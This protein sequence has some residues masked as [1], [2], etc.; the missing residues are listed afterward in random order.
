MRL[1]AVAVAGRGLVPPHEPVFGADDEAL[2]RGRAAFETV[3]VYGGRPFRLDAHLERLGASSASL[4][5]P[6][7]RPAELEQIVALAVE[8]AGE[9]ESGLRLYWT[10]STLAAT[11]WQL[12]D[13]LDALRASGLRFASIALSV[14][15][16]AGIKSTSY[17][18]NWAAQAEASRRGADDAILVTADGVVLEAPTAN[19]WWRTGGVLSTP[20]VDVGI[21]PGVTRAVL[22]ELAPPLGYRICEGTFSLDELREAEEAFTSSSLREVVPA[23]V[24]DGSP[25]GDGAPGPA[26]AALQAALRAESL[27]R[28]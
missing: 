8:A 27:T 1:L 12:P 20:A 7:P 18:A 21:L 9:P 15:L 3:R 6:A 23:V 24:L 22:L 16:L 17:A 26:A 5:I 10:G 13:D 11:V 28:D 25:I 2:L 4:G 14:P 19:V